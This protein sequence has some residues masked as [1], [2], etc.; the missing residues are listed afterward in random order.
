MPIRKPRHRYKSKES[1]QILALEAIAKLSVNSLLAIVA[2]TALV[3]LGSY[4]A[5]QQDKLQLLEGEVQASQSQLEAERDDFHYHFDPTQARNIMQ[6]QSYRV[7]PGQ[8][9]IIFSPAA[10]QEDASELD[11]TVASPSLQPSL[12]SQPMPEFSSTSD[13]TPMPQDSLP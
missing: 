6:E 2:L 10:S 3:R 13:S 4:N 9:Q 7:E 8:A 11:S 5:A 1:A 12:E